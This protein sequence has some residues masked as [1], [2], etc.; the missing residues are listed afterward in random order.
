M[1]ENNVTIGDSYQDTYSDI[2]LT[3]I[4]ILG[5][6]SNGLLLLAFFKD[7]LKCFRNS[8]TYFVTNL[9]ISD[10]LTCL[11]GLFFYITPNYMTGENRKIILF[12]FTS[13]AIVSLV[14]LTS[15]SIDRFLMVT[16]P[17]K[18]RILMKGKV[19]VLCLAVIWIFGCSLSGI[20]LLYGRQNKIYTY[21]SGAINITL[22]AVIYAATYHK[23]KKQSRNIALQNSRESRAQE[24]RILKEK[25]FLNTII[26][27][28]CVAFLC[29]VPSML[30]FQIINPNPSNFSGSILVIEIFTKIFSLFFHANFAVNPIIYVIRL[31]NYRKTFHLLY[32]RRARY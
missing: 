20:T 16:Y 7:P 4:C 9:S 13:F 23:L 18:H 8:A 6:V 15:I 28:A 2:P 24:I 31:P 22:S 27:I 21:N 30:F 12:F 3:T 14:S 10:C 25:K 29:I 17:I 11:F 1:A 19:I 26:L 32:C 5:V